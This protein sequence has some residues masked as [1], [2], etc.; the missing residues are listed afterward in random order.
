M[1]KVIIVNENRSELFSQYKILIVSSSYFAVFK[2][3]ILRGQ[4]K[5]LQKFSWHSLHKNK[6]NWEIASNHENMNVECTTSNPNSA[7]FS[8]TYYTGTC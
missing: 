6:I 4:Q 5:I 3:P 1:V 7:G 8:I 2:V